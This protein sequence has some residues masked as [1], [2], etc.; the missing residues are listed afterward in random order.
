MPQRQG[1][2]F[3]RWWPRGQ[4]LQDCDVCV[5]SENR[6]RSPAWAP[7]GGAA[8]GP[9][10]LMAAQD[11]G[12]ALPRTGPR[13]LRAPA[14]RLHP[15]GSGRGPVRGAARPGCVLRRTRPRAPPRPPR[16]WSTLRGVLTSARRRRR[17]RP[18]GGISSA[19]AAAGPALRPARP[20]R[21][22]PD[23]GRPRP[24]GPGE[25][26][27]GAAPRM[28]RSPGT[29]LKPAKYIPVATAA[30]LLVGSSTLF[31]VFT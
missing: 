3:T 26:C 16:C 23:P 9:R 15:A 7:R 13:G 28:P 17:R 22:R 19:A 5:A 6:G 4:G 11:A 30:A 29:R 8:A 20:A 27:G 12:R 1:L 21:P 18:R 2:A 31:F 10:V 25:G 24:P 14:R